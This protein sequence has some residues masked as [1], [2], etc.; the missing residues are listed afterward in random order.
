MSKKLGIIGCQSKHA[1]FF[2]SIFN[3][4]LAFPGYGVEYIFADDEPGRMPYV[5]GK[6]KI[7]N[8]CRTIAEL[9]DL[10][11]AVLI[12][13][14]LAQTHFTP[15]MQCIRHNKPVFIDKPF[16]LSVRDAMD[17]AEASLDRRV[18]VLGGSTLCFDPL[19]KQSSQ[20]TSK[21]QFGV[22]AYKA[23][24]ESP[25]GGYHFYGSHLTDLCS[26][27]F[28]TDNFS[29]KSVRIGDTVNTTLSSARQMIVLHTQPNLTKPQVIFD[30]GDSLQNLRF[31]DQLCYLNGMRAFVEAIESGKPDPG[32]LRQLVFSVRL[33]DAMMRSLELGEEVY[34]DQQ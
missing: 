32:R 6:A 14:R 29:V 25:F 26:V 28:G 27:L 16:T 23:D 5:L 12:T 2:G 17:I 30:D 24:P 11:D 19:V 10:S 13:T 22:I 8:V 34:L 20:S 4:D 18:P 33:L 3:I 1:E 15:A 31:D 21:S 7:P 9:I